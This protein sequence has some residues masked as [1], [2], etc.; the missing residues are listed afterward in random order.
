MSRRVVLPVLVVALALAACSGSGADSGSGSSG[1]AE[2]TA[3]ETGAEDELVGWMGEFCAAHDSF[4]R[5]LG[6]VPSLLEEAPEPPG[7]EDRARLVE[8]L[9]V[10]LQ[11]LDGGHEAALGLPTPPTAARDLAE[12]YR[13]TLEEAREVTTERREHAV[14][15]PVPE[16]ES[17]YMLSRL[18]EAT[19]TPF[20][21]RLSDYV[22]LTH[23]DL[24]EPYEAAPTCR[25]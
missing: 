22:E 19:W 8:A 10:R 3:E 20:D 18:D 12:A 11:V 5:S 16:L 23:P 4:L 24:T 15:F 6:D 17:V 2:Q 21:E 14:L 9:T 25:Q 13:A 1:E 7:E